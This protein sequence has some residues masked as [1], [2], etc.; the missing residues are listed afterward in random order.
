MVPTNAEGGCQSVA[1]C[2]V[3]GAPSS[4]WSG[5]APGGV[6]ASA[7]EGS[8]LR[9]S[10]PHAGAV[11]RRALEMHR[12]AEPVAEPL[13]DGKPYP[14]P[15]PARVGGSH[16]RFE[17]R[18]EL[19]LRNAGPGVGD[20]QRVALH[21]HLD[22][23]GPGVLNRIAQQVADEHRQHP[24]VG[25]DDDRF[26]DALLDAHR[27]GP[28]HGAGALAFL[29]HDVVQADR[30][31]RQPRIGRPGE[32]Q[33]RFG[34]S[35]HLVHRAVD[36]G[37][38]LARLRIELRAPAQ[39]ARGE[40]HH[41]QRGAQLVTRIAGEVP[42]A[43]DVLVHV[44]RQPPQRLRQSENLPIG[45]RRQPLRL[46]R[47]R[48]GRA[49]VEAAHLPGEP[50][51]RRHRTP[52]EPIA[53]PRR[54]VQDDQHARERHQAEPQRKLAHPLAVED[55]KQRVAVVLGDV[56]HREAGGGVQVVNPGR[57]L[58][59]GCGH[60]ASVRPAGQV[61]GE[62]AGVG[63]GKP[64]RLRKPSPEVLGL[65]LQRAPDQDFLDGGRRRVHSDDRR[66]ADE[67]RLKH[68]D[69][70]QTPAESDRALSHPEGRAGSRRSAG[71]E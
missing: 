27:P 42:L 56:D 46:E 66:R 53:E 4:A 36:S 22:L 7:T 60:A 13:H 11:T 47:R 33:E 55:E 49:R 64:R 19:L 16:E 3:A 45:V 59:D 68:E 69:A 17:H 24:G 9:E 30:G 10:D 21:P 40:P 52:R 8:A 70:P 2:A 32:Q 50:D 41:R 51:G 6:A 48:I 71:C 31:G 43:L 57:E 34:H 12:P 67:G 28:G 35:L 29:R 20:C 5:A 44:P 26:G 62:V 25:L 65:L 63:R 18:I 38:G 15:V 1:W 37:D 54:E 61:A 23:P 39:R 14:V 58:R